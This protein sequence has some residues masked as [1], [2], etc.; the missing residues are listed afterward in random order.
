[1]NQA[2]LLAA[3]LLLC[4]IPFMLIAAALAGRSAV[5]GLAVRLGLSQ[6]AAEDVGHLFTSSEAT[7]AEVTGL[8]WLFFVLGGV[9]AA[10]S[11]QVL[12]QRVF[13]LPS[14][15]ALDRLLALIWLAL[16]VG[17]FF[18][19]TS[20]EQPFHKSAPVLWWIVNVPALCGFWWF[21]MWFLLAKR[22]AWR[23]L[24][25][26]AVFTGLFWVGMLVVF[27]IIFSGMVTGYY[28]EYG[29]IGVVFALMSFLIAV[30]VVIILGA[31]C[32]MVWRERDMSF[33]AAAA[34]RR[35]PS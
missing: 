18:V 20:M 19:E 29:A 28:R 22:V 2:M 15:G 26:C 14:R 35:R 5:S 7:R 34:K 9:A 21:T 13:H 33:R 25:P 6:Q 24:L 30:G 12:Y 1:M 17:W 16:A 27:H 32:G 3:I 10:S 11:I 8:S 4:A 31:A 23:Q